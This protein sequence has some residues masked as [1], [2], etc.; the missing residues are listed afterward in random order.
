M[1]RQAL[2][3]GTKTVTVE[4]GFSGAENEPVEIAEVDFQFQGHSL[5]DSSKILQPVPD[6]RDWHGM[7]RRSCSFSADD[8]TLPLSWMERCSSMGQ[9]G[10][11]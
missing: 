10:L 2:V 3:E 8:A 1:W 11:G 6:G 4:T 5:R 9:R 7:E